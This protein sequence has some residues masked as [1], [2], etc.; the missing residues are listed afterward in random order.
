MR[1]TKYWHL[2]K[3]LYEYIYVYSYRFELFQKKSLRPFHI[4]NLSVRSH[5]AGTVYFL[6]FCCCCSCVKYELFLFD[7]LFLITLCHAAVEV[8]GDCGGNQHC[9]TCCVAF[10]K[11]FWEKHGV[12][13]LRVNTVVSVQY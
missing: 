9:F 6:H 11:A 5:S 12:D 2:N 10:L 4:Q 1:A 3:N 8:A 7:P 13:M